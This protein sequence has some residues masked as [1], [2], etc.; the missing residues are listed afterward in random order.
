MT[1]E[2]LDSGFPTSIKYGEI[3]KC[4]PGYDPVKIKKYDLLY[5]GGEAFHKHIGDFLV[6]RQIEKSAEGAGHWDARSEKAWYVPRGPGLIDWLVAEVFKKDVKIVCNNGTEEQKAYWE[7]LNT[8][9]DGL[10]GSLS[11]AARD[12]LRQILIHGRGSFS[13]Q[14]TDEVGQA[15]D[16]ESQEGRIRS[17]PA[18]MVDDCEYDHEGNLVMMRTHHKTP[19][20]ENLWSQPKDVEKSWTYFTREYVVEYAYTK[21][22]EEEPDEKYDVPRVDDF[23][24][25]FGEIPIFPIRA[26][27]EMS[28]FS[29][30][31][32]E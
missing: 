28:H 22:I 32:N 23:K 18:C 13:V 25:D 4:G 29:V 12:A 21:P 2:Q 17:L 27:R 6:K 7:G 14:F 9:A 15:T 11:T 30:M 5:D 16:P 1:E 10:G 26:G 24:H 20:R 31:A 3:K 8:N 19:V